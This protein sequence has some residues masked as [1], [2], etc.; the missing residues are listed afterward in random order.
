MDELYLLIEIES[1]FPLF[2]KLMVIPSKVF[3]SPSSNKKF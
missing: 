1:V 2:V 3:F